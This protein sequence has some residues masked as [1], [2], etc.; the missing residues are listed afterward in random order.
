MIDLSMQ[1][2][3]GEHP[4]LNMH[5]FSIVRNDAIGGHVSRL[6]VRVAAHRHLQRITRAAPGPSDAC[7]A[8]TRCPCECHSKPQDLLS[9]AQFT[10]FRPSLN[11]RTTDP[12]PSSI[13]FCARPTTGSED[14]CLRIAE[15]SYHKC[16][17]LHVLPLSVGSAGRKCSEH[18]CML[19]TYLETHWWQ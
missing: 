18:A 13:S 12:G 9:G 8:S 7:N 16:I 14:T 2:T 15:G 19:S 3:S 17:L 4:M 6:S 10:G 1:G 5:S 11:R